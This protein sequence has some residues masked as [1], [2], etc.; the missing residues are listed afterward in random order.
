MIL[1]ASAFGFRSVGAQDAFDKELVCV[2]IFQP[3]FNIPDPLWERYDS[4]PARGQLQDL[5]NLKIPELLFCSTNE[6]FLSIF[7]ILNDFTRYFAADILN[8]WQIYGI[9]EAKFSPPT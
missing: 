3:G 5:F 2:H 9:N 7:F 4:T 1:P 8:L 6:N